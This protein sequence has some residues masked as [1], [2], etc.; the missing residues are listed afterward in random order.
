MLL[1]FR[2]RNFRSAKDELILDLEASA[3]KDLKEV[4]RKPAGLV[5]KSHG[6][7]PVATI[8][9]ANA[10]GKT[11]L[12]KAAKAL[13][14]MVLRGAVLT[15]DFWTLQGLISATPPASPEPF[16]FDAESAKA[17][18]CLEV[19][20]LIGSVRY[21]YGFESTPGEYQGQVIIRS[22]WLYSWPKGQR[23][24]VFV[25][26]FKDDGH[27]DY[28][29]SIKVSGD[30]FD[31][32]IKRALELHA[33]T[34]DDTLFISAATKFN[35]KQA[36]AVSD[37][38]RSRFVV[39]EV[40]EQPSFSAT[41]RL[42]KDTPKAAAFITH[43]LAAT[44]TGVSEVKTFA[45]LYDDMLQR[46]AAQERG[47]FISEARGMQT[48][49]RDAAGVEYWLSLED[50]S[51]GT[52]RLI[53]L[54]GHIYL[55]LEEGRCLWVDELNHSL[56][57]WLLRALVGLFQNPEANPN[58]AQLIF[59]T[60]DPALMDPTLLRR[61]QIW[62]TE[63]DSARS[64]T[65]YSLSDIEDK[66]RKSQPLYKSFLSGRFGG[67]PMQLDAERLLHWNRPEGA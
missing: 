32:G 21:A 7:L 18:T 35:Q 3:D 20:F 37:W 9:G 12:I 52:Q 26:E 45:N 11:T 56:H 65:L 67:V 24:E 2:L 60:H 13:R 17:T 34:R 10:S 49:H 55:A 33:N 8:F 61:D 40:S 63:K 62:I 19:E 57:H 29:R 44:G 25:R 39:M 6:V 46:M 53:S 48:L 16:R 51:L 14:E 23:V 22:E 28:T 5:A 47:E 31:G 66:P 15:D 59:T 58:G 36:M 42:L 27:G 43:L 38:F 54:A 50:E 30:Y 41:R 1:K 64:T 4:V